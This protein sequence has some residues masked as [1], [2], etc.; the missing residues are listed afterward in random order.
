MASG[1]IGN[2]QFVVPD[3][4]LHAKIARQVW[5]ND[6]WSVTKS[7][8]NSDTAFFNS[9]SIQPDLM[10]SVFQTAPVFFQIDFLRMKRINYLVIGALKGQW[11]PNGDR[12]F[13]LG[14]R[15]A[16]G[17]NIVY[18]GAHTNLAYTQVRGH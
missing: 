10:K 8:R 12:K 2:N 4:P 18:S 15:N 9:L 17:K 13:A 16:N 1:F 6:G 14:Y 7:Y 5:K 3:S 11:S